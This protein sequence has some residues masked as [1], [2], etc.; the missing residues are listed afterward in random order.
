MTDVTLVHPR[1]LVGFVL[2]DLLIYMCVLL[3]VVCPFLIF[4]LAIVFQERIMHTKLDI[5]VLTQWLSQFCHILYF[6]FDGTSLCSV[7]ECER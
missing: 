3:I 2:L 4:P 5:Y 7:S 6:L 1:F